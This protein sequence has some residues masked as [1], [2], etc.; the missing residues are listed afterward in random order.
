[1]RLFDTVQTMRAVLGRPQAPSEADLKDLALDRGDVLDL[2]ASPA[3]A[4]GRMVFVAER[5]GVS[6]AQLDA[7]RG[8][9]LDAARTCAHCG[10]T[11]ACEAYRSGKQT[12]FSASQCPNATRFSDMAIG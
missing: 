6:E 8:L 3:G 5:F 7:N 2:L 9:A 10:A 12:T 4:R 1:M 11:R